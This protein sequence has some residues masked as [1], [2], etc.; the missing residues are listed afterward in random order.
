MLP[1]SSRAV[2]G[3]AIIA[4]LGCL[5]LLLNSVPISVANLP[6]HSA[7]PQQ[8]DTRLST[9]APTQLPKTIK[10]GGQ[11]P[12]FDAWSAAKTRAQR[13]LLIYTSQLLTEANVTFWL[14]SGNLLALV[15]NSSFT[16]KNDDD[17]DF[18]VLGSDDHKVLALRDKVKADGHTLMVGAFTPKQLTNNNRIGK[19][20]YDSFD[21]NPSCYPDPRTGCYGIR[22][23]VDQSNDCPQEMI[24]P[25]QQWCIDDDG[26]GLQTCV[27]VP[28]KPE[29]YLARV[30]GKNWKTPVRK[31]KLYS[32]SSG[33]CKLPHTSECSKGC[34]TTGEWCTC[35][36][37]CSDWC[38]CK[39]GWLGK[40]SKEF[41]CGREE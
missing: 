13:E 31:D 29:A 33:H 39:N 14:R 26:D 41:N 24:L 34:S 9:P 3:L 16:L 21:G 19:V 6:N 7:N 40:P 23:L 27:A 2:V 18:G 4:V 30:Y 37:T 22:T 38:I 36:N 35:T 28:N 17:V 15:R 32:G 20:F 10:C 11:P 12:W 8:P 5:L 25:T 1:H